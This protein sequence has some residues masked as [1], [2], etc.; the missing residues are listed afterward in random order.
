MV[1]VF[2]N[3]CTIEIKIAMSDDNK[4]YRVFLS[5]AEAS[6]DSHC[7]GLITALKQNSSNIEF[8]GVGCD[9][10]EAAGCKLIE[11]TAGNAAMIYNALGKVVSFYKTIRRITALLKTEKFDL[12]IVCDSPAFNFHV[13]K[14]AKKAGG[15]T[16]FYVAPQ[17]WAWGQWRLD[18]LRKC[19]DRLACILPFEQQWFQSK[20]LNATFVGNP[21][22]DDLET[23]LSCFEREYDSFKPESVRLVLCPG[24]REAEI[25]LL[26]EPMQKIAVR[27][28]RKYPQADFTAVVLSEE[29][30]K[31]LK[32][33]HVLGF[34]C[35]YVIGSVHQ[36]A[37]N[38]DMAI[39]ASGSATL[40]VAA[41][42]CPMVVMYQSCKILWHLL[43]RWLLKTPHL[44]LVNILAK[45]ELV[46]EFM[47][48]FTSI[49]PIVESVVRLLEDNH[50]LSQTSGQLIRLV[51]PLKQDNA[52]ANAS[53]IV[54]EM[55][56]GHQQ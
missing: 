7:A 32:A 37:L 9:K 30:K 31:T 43:G 45:K 33:R 10:M 15:K 17:L 20:G 39:V 25:D 18:K 48:Y 26:W 8:V 47:P 5:A 52:A 4:T 11:N 1:A 22:L 41:A 46:P 23:D 16:F 2:V 42:G 54:M 34:R 44:S 24:S 12:V 27:I 14:A 49:D 35:K 51:Q 40:Q 36:A 19:C 56:D 3:N 13:A 38:A 21:L 50:T 28:K 6:G 55:L 29:K 53:K